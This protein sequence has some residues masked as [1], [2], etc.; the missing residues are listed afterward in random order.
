MSEEI[1]TIFVWYKKGVGRNKNDI[2]IYAIDETGDLLVRHVSSGVEFFERDAGLTS[3]HSHHKYLGK[4][5]NG[6]YYVKKIQDPERPENERNKRF[7]EAYQTFK[8]KYDYKP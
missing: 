3:E 1:H 4:F 6:N 2:A 8:R 7:K 5:P